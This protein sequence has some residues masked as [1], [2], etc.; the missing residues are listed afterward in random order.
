MQITTGWLF[1][2]FGRFS[3]LFYSSDEATCK[4]TG[5]RTLDTRTIY[6]SQGNNFPGRKLLLF[7]QAAGIFWVTGPIPLHWILKGQIW[8]LLYPSVFKDLVLS[9]CLRPYNDFLT[10][11]DFQSLPI[12]FHLLNTVSHLYFYPPPRDSDMF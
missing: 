3:V 12:F 11:H 1:F 4:G 7:H 2:F 6:L 5:S 10:G 9:S 8:R